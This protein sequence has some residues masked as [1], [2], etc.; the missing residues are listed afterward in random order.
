MSIEI[1]A[2]SRQVQE[3]INRQEITDVLL[4]YLD[5]ADRCDFERQYQSSFHP[6]AVFIYQKGNEPVTA[7]AFFDQIKSGESLGRGF[8]QTMHYLSNI[9]IRLDG[10]NAAV[11]SLIFAQHLI[12]ADCPHMPPNFPNLGKDYGLLIGAR[13]NDLFAR[14]NGLWRI[15][16]RELTYEWDA[17]IDPSTIRGPLSSWRKL[18]S[19]DLWDYRPQS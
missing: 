8:V 7:R 12:S 17:R 10:D 1:V 18:V 13:Y 15:V 16:R 5:C 6:D 4:T 2:L 14:R 3:L 9:L 19:S 11:Q